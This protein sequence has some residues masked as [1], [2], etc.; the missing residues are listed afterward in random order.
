[1]EIRNF[2]GGGRSLCGPQIYISQAKNI[3][4]EK[5]WKYDC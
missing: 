2:P 3:L 1:M 4:K 5:K